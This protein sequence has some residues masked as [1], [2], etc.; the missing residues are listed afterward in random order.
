MNNDSVTHEGHTF[1]ST[2]QAIAWLQSLPDEPDSI[3]ILTPPK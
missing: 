2:E 1:N 3:I